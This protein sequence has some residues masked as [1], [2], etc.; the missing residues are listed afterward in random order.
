MAHKEGPPK[1]DAD[2]K[3]I[4]ASMKH[5]LKKIDWK[6][7]T[8]TYR[9][10]CL[11]KRLYKHAEHLDLVECWVLD[12]EDEQTTLASAQKKV[13]KLLLMLQSKAEDLEAC[14][15]RKNVRIVGVTESIRVDNMERYVEQL[16][17]DLLA[18]E[19]SSTIFVVEQVHHTVAPRPAPSA[20]LCPSIVRLLNH[21]DKD[22]ALR[23]ACDLGILRHD[24]M[25]IS[26]YS[27]LMQQMQGK[28]RLQ[29][30]NAICFIL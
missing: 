23:K 16:L 21:R 29:E 24:G 9:T 3:Q 27:V 25:E 13:D 7:D 14:S 1:S 26:L 11:S 12:D 15:H 19:T 5:S 2:L 10:D 30:S 8:L 6:I 17:S 28:Q 22:A 20:P 4:L 18:R